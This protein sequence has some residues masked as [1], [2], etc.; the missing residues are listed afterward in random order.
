VCEP[1]DLLRGSEYSSLMV[2]KT[3]LLVGPSVFL[4][5]TCSMVINF[6]SCADARNETI[7][8]FLE[9]EVGEIRSE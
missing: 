2:L 1:K 7:L 8:F 5:L 9:G 4:S 3:V 6:V